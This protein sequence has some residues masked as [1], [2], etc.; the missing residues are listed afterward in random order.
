MRFPLWIFTVGV[1]SCGA[2]LLWFAVPGPTALRVVLAT[3]IVLAALTFVWWHSLRPSNLRDWQPDVAREATAQIEGNLVTVRN[4]RNFH[5]RSETDFDERWEERTLDLAKLDGLDIFFSHWSSPLIAH[6]IMSWSFAD[7]QHLAISIETRKEKGVQYS[8]LA[9]F[10]RQYEL[11]YIAA[12]ERD[13]VK[14][15]TNYRG[16]D[17]YVYRL[18]VTQPAAKALLLNYFEAMNALRHEPRWYNA[19]VANCTTAIRQRVIDAGGKV[20]LSWKLFANGYLPELLYQRGSLDTNGPFTELKAMSYVNER[21]RTVGEG[22]D[23][24]AKIREGL[25][26]PRLPN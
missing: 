7:R 13:V 5:Y 3:V 4:V 15:R 2:A 17:V 23:F 6:T 19:L 21:A 11:I 1:A 8:A 10:F 12:D 16:E 25:P 14:L 18:R 22:E 9:G 24:S 20:S 26:M